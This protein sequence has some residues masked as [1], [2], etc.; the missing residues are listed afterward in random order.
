VFVPLIDEDG[1]Q[2]IDS[3]VVSPMPTKV[4]RKLGAE[5][6]IAVDLLSCGST[7]RGTRRAPCSEHFPVGDDAYADDVETSTLH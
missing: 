6:V 1:R 5:I 4:V 3:G 7:F 2:L